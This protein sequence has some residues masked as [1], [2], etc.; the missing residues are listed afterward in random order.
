[1]ANQE[2]A[3]STCTPSFSIKFEFII[4]IHVP[5]NLSS[6][7]LGLPHLQQMRHVHELIVSFLRRECVTVNEYRGYAGSV[8]AWTV[9]RGRAIDVKT[10]PDPNFYDH[11]GWGYFGVKLGTPVYPYQRL[12]FFD[13]DRVLTLIKDEY[14]T[15]VNESCSMV[16]YVG[17]V[18]ASYPENPHSQGFPLCTMQTLLQL[19]WKFEAQIN[20][21]HQGHRVSNPRCLTPSKQLADRPN[22]T[23]MDAINS[24][25]DLSELYN[26]WEGHLSREQILQRVPAYSI[27]RLTNA[28]QANDFNGTIRFGQHAGTLDFDEMKNWT[29]LM[30]CLVQMAINRGACGIPLGILMLGGYQEQAPLDKISPIEFVKIIGMGDQYRFYREKLGTDIRDRQ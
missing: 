26:R 23:I 14:T 5:S 16:L 10:V 12:N 21:L 7:A 28:F 22:K 9:E 30:G 24:C 6:Q 1:M 11:E 20:A 18:T 8:E 19:L 3:D 25:T 4:K 27:R 17:N 2:T 13:I 15:F 29:W